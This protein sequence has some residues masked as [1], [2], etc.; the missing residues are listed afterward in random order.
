MDVDAI[1][2]KSCAALRDEFFLLRRGR[3]IS[4]RVASSESEEFSS[5]SARLKSQSWSL[6]SSSSYVDTMFGALSVSIG[7]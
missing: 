6:S 5:Q 7:S 1:D 2:K 3:F 4:A